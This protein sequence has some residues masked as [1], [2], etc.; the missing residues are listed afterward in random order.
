MSIM[1]LSLAACAS[2]SSQESVDESQDS[3]ATTQEETDVE[4]NEQADSEEVADEITITHEYGEVTIPVNPQS[5]VVLDYGL[6]DALDYAGVESITGVPVG[7]G[8]PESLKAYEA[9][10]YVNVGSLKEADYEAISALAPD[11]IFITDRMAS[12]YEELNNIAPTVYMPM[13]GATYMDTFKS[14]MQILSEIFVDQ[15]DE[16]TSQVSAIEERIEAIKEKSAG[17]T[18]LVSQVSDGELSVFGYGSRYG[19][20]Y[21]NLGFTLEDESIEQSTHGQSSNYEY[22]AEQNPDYLFV[23]DRSAAIS[24]EGAQTAAEL[25]DND[26]INATKAATEGHIVYLDSTNWYVVSGGINSTLS[27][28]SEIEAALGIQ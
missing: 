27:M 26:L 11:V 16:F 25:L 22:I 6:L 1:I 17:S 19:L 12:N 18:A 10:T 7:S 9:D 24:T 28:I 5:V 3:A 20:V 2:N 21:E 14:N 8:L 13:P 4:D 15:A 23:V